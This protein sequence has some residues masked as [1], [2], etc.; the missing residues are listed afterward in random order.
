[1]KRRSYDDI[2]LKTLG[3]S[4]LHTAVIYAYIPLVLTVSACEA[5]IAFTRNSYYFFAHEIA[6]HCNGDDVLLIRKE[7]S[8]TSYEDLDYVDPSGCFSF[9]L[10][11]KLK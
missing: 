3:N 5:H 7:T 1:V 6:C 2:N 11:L 9:K 10:P 4:T 8:T